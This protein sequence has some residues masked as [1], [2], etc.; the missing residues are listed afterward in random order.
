MLR[1]GAALLLVHSALATE[2]TCGVGYEPVGEKCLQLTGSGY[3]FDE[4]ATTECP[5]RGGHIAAIAS[6]EEFDAVFDAVTGGV[7]GEELQG[8]WPGGCGFVGLH[9]CN[10]QETWRWTTGDAGTDAP[11]GD[12]EPNDWA[13]SEDC[14]MICDHIDGGLNDG[15]CHNTIHCICEEGLEELVRYDEGQCPEP[16]WAGWYTLAFLLGFFFWLCAIYGC[17]G[18]PQMC[19][20]HK[21]F[22]NGLCLGIVLFCI[23]LS[24]LW[25]Y[26]VKASYGMNAGVH[27]SGMVGAAVGFLAAIALAAYTRHRMALD[28]DEYSPNTP[29]LE[30]VPVVPTQQQIVQIQVPPNACPGMPVQVRIPDGRIVSVPIPAGIMP[31]QIISVAV[32]A[33]APIVSSEEIPVAEAYQAE[34][35]S[36]A[37]LGEEQCVICQDAIR[38]GHERLPCSHVFHRACLERWLRDR[39]HRFCPICKKPV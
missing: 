6:Q 21:D 26:I 33:P 7:T 20:T 32:P 9:R 22:A 27:T 39:E 14:G 31:G 15:P 17:A 29:A 3:T 4:C 38:G 19:S 25:E 11:W 13:G 10:A 23:L 37:P 8:G 16:D 30:M 36:G 5:N 28:N 1:A 34:R 12:G 2:S 18:L 35:V 24:A